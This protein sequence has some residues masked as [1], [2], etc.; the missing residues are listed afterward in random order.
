MYISEE[1]WLLITVT[2][3]NAFMMSHYSVTHTLNLIICKHYWPHMC[4]FIQNYI[5][6]C[7]KCNQ[8]KLITHTIYR[9]LTSLS[10][11][12]KPWFYIEMNLITDLSVTCHT[13]SDC[14][15]IVIDVYI[16]MTHFIAIIKVINT[17][18]IAELLW[19]HVIK[20]HS[21]FKIIVSDR[22]KQ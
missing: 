6:Q 7:Q 3:H 19:Q 14:I 18:D 22:N 2:H 8:N 10:V 1:M 20:H 12:E 17:L 13:Q 11:S 15:L 21:V 9:A 4:K 16:K 5:H